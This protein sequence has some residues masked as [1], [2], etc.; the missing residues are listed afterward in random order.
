MDKRYRDNRSASSHANLLQKTWS[1][2]HRCGKG[3]SLLSSNTH[4]KSSVWLMM[5]GDENF[6][7]VGKLIVQLCVR[8]CG[9]VTV[10]EK[11]FSY[12]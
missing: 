11:A 9:L 4:G 6:Y 10:G 7:A 1:G 12:C 3:R 2:S 8:G 5:D